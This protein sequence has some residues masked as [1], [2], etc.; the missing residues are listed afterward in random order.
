MLNMCNCNLNDICV[1][2]SQ[3]HQKNCRGL[4]LLCRPDLTI[5]GEH[6]LREGKL[7]KICPTS[8]YRSKVYCQLWKQLSRVILRKTPTH[9]LGNYTPPWTRPITMTHVSL[10]TACIWAILI[11]ENIIFP[12]LIIQISILW[13]KVIIAY[14]SKVP[15][16]V[17]FSDLDYSW[18]INNY[19][20]D[21][22]WETT[23]YWGNKG[24]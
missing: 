10:Y 8:V 24:F 13:N 5:S 11:P 17:G 16:V 23:V 4:C 12:Y 9:F 18:P 3:N 22:G 21:C 7:C 20:G 1:I 14:S 2:S 15:S 6:I 19:N